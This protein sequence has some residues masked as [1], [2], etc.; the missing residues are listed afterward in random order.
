MPSI[1]HH[2]IAAVALVT[3]LALVS[4]AMEAAAKSKPTHAR[5]LGS[6][7]VGGYVPAPGTYPSNMGARIP[8]PPRSNGGVV[9]DNTAGW[10][11]VGAF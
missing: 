9:N 3:T 4:F 10:G 2:R 6:G 1:K 8:P 7:V 11:N 5:S